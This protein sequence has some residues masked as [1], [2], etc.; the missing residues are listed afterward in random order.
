MKKRKKVGFYELKK[1]F[2]DT[3]VLKIY[4]VAKLSIFMWSLISS[5]LLINIIALFKYNPYKVIILIITGICFFGLIHVLTKNLIR[6]YVKNYKKHKK[7]IEKE[8]LGWKGCRYALFSDNIKNYLYNKKEVIK[9]INKE[10]SIKK[11]NLF[12]NPAFPIF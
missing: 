5:F 7:I 11:F 1:E 2:D 6:Y 4:R 9:K 3:T 12:K 8:K 10:I